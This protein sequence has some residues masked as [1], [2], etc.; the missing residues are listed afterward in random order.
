VYYLARKLILT[1]LQSPARVLPNYLGSRREARELFKKP[2]TSGGAGRQV[3]HSG[4]DSRVFLLAYANVS[5]HSEN[6]SERTLAYRKK[7]RE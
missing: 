5:C 6:T 2:I 7:K 1:F 4:Q 3:S